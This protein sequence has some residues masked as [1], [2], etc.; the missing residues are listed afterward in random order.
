[1]ATYSVKELRQSIKEKVMELGVDPTFSSNP[2]FDA[3]IDRFD[4][5][6][7]DMTLGSDADHIIVNQDVTKLEFEWTNSEGKEYKYIIILQNPFNLIC[8]STEYGFS[9]HDEKLKRDIFCKIAMEQII[10]YSDSLGV[11]TMQEN[12]SVAYNNKTNVNECS[13]NTWT[14]ISLYT[15][16]GIMYEQEYKGFEGSTLTGNIEDISISS[17]LFIPREGSRANN[18]FSDKFDQRTLL[19][20]IKMDI[21]RVMHVEPKRKVKYSAEVL[22]DKEHGL[23][24]MRLMNANIDPYPRDIKIDPL[25][26]AEIE[27]ILSKEDPKVREGLQPFVVG[28]N[29]YSY[30]SFTDSHYLYE[31]PRR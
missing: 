5:Y 16:E 19:R 2:S 12:G 22:L 6:I 8:R 17:M 14:S 28:R 29:T 31:F 20:R 23:R 3:V 30:D 1:M 15:K 27:E 13:N 26:D 21:A 18:F 10:E 25:S 24:D 9:H 4:S 11:T 7:A